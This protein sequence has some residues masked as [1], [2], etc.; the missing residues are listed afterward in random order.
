MS[1]KIKGNSLPLT[2]YVLTADLKYFAVARNAQ[3]HFFS[4]ES[5]NMNN[6]IEMMSYSI[7][8]DFLAQVNVSMLSE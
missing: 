2:F 5:S 6:F 1:V 3:R 4:L 7:E 8:I